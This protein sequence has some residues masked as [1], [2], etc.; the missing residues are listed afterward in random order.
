[1]KCAYCLFFISRFA[2]L[3][4]HMHFAVINYFFSKLLLVVTIL[5]VSIYFWI[6]F[7]S[8]KNNN[9]V[10]FVIYK[11]CFSSFNIVSHLH[12]HL[13]CHKYL[14]VT[15]IN[16]KMVTKTES[17]TKEV[18]N[19]VFFGDSWISKAIECYW[20]VFTPVYTL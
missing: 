4:F 14:T 2:L 19:L 10:L 13:P 5:E 16:T 6:G 18:Q 3:F 12:S 9:S 7:C 11:Q 17:V 8:G 1:M 20:L 15:Y